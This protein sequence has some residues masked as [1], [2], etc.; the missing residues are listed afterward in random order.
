[1]CNFIEYKGESVLNTGKGE[2]LTDLVQIVK[3]YTAAMRLC[4]SL[5]GLT[6]TTTSSSRWRL[7]TATWN[8]WT[9]TT[10]TCAS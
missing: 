10:V 6:R 3:L 9:N 4:S 7:C 5:R 8:R 2:G 1:M